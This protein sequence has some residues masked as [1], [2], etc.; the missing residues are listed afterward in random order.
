MKIRELTKNDAKIYFD[1]FD[2]EFT[3]DYFDS[4]DEGYLE[5]RS[6][7]LKFHE[8]CKKNKEYT[9]DLEMGLKLYSFFK[10]KKWFNDSVASNYDFW[11]Y[12]CI[13][14]APDIIYE[15][16]GLVDSYY[17]EKNV[18]IYFSTIWWYIHMSFQG[19]IDK[20]REMLSR[21]NTDYILQLVERPGRE[22]MYLKISREIIRRICGLSKEELNKKI[23]NANLFRRLL[24]LNT[25]K[26]NNYN[27]LLENNVEKYV[28]DLLL[29]CNVRVN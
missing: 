27:L 3:N 2:G 22:G 14:V 18:R 11:R 8:V 29:E 5:I 1:D 24:I 15:R 23:G 26:L 7:I 20:T 17:Y 12:I 19:R 13:K 16:H 10:T 6:E 28:A 21:L 4:L 9:Y 25:A